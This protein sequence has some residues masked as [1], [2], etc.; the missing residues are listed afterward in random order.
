MAYRIDPLALNEL[1]Q[2]LYKNSLEAQVYAEQ[3]ARR[4]QRE[5]ESKGVFKNILEGMGGS[6][7]GVGSG[8]ARFVGADETANW[9]DTKGAELAP[10]KEFKD[11][12]S[13]EYF[14]DPRGALRDVS[15]QLGSMVA[16]APAAVVAGAA[17]PASVPVGVASVLGGS[18][19]RV[20][21]SKIAQNLAGKLGTEVGK[22]AIVNTGRTIAGGLGSGF[23]ESISEGGSA[24]SSA[25]MAGKSADDSR[26]IGNEVAVNNMPMLMAS[27][28][29]EY[30][31]LGGKL[32]NI[33]A[34]T[35][36]GAAARFLKS[37]FR[38]APQVVINALQNSG[39]ELIQQTISDKALGK[40]VGDLWN[41]S[42]WT[43]GQKEAFSKSLISSG[44][45][46][47]MAGL[48]HNNK[49]FKGT[50]ML[51]GIDTS[52]GVLENLSPEQY[53]AMQRQLADM[54]NEESIP[55]DD[56]GI[57]GMEETQ[58]IENPDLS[59]NPLGKA[60]A[61][62]YNNIMDE[63][64]S[65]YNKELR[66]IS[67]YGDDF[68]E[69]TLAKAER[70]AQDGTVRSVFK[71]AI[72][73]DV[74]A[75]KAIERQPLAVK[76]AL[77]GTMESLWKNTIEG[78]NNTEDTTERFDNIPLPTED[79]TNGWFTNE[80]NQL[81]HPS[82]NVKV[83]L[84][85]NQERIIG[86]IFSHPTTDNNNL[87]GKED[88]RRIILERALQGDVEAQKAFSRQ[89][90]AIKRA[91][92]D[93]HQKL[94]SGQDKLD[95]EVRNRWHLGEQL[96]VNAIPQEQLTEDKQSR[97]NSAMQSQSV[98][99]ALQAAFNGDRYAQRTIS[100]YPSYIKR[101][102]FNRD[103]EE[104]ANKETQQIQ[105]MDIVEQQEFR[106]QE[107][108]SIT[109]F[110]ENTTAINESAV[111][112]AMQANTLANEQ[113]VSSEKEV[114]VPKPVRNKW[115]TK[116]LAKVEDKINTPLTTAQTNEAAFALNDKSLASLFKRAMRGDWKS[117]KE[118]SEKSQIVRAALFKREEEVTARNLEKKKKALLA[119]LVKNE[120][121]AQTQ[122]TRN[123]L[124][125][126]GKSIA[127]TK[128][129]SKNIAVG[130]VERKQGEKAQTVNDK[131]VAT[132]QRV[133]GK[134]AEVR[135]DDN[136]NFNVRYR[137]AEADDLI[138]SHLAKNSDD[139]AINPNYPQEWQ[140][141]SRDRRAMRLQI[142]TMVN[143]LNPADLAESRNINNGSPLVNKE[144]IVENGN[145]RTIAITM[146]HK[147]NAPSRA[148]YIQYLKDNA[149][150]FGF[151]KND[152]EALSNPILVRERIDEDIEI[153]KIINSVDGGARLGASEQALADSKKITETTLTFYDKNSKGDL[154]S[155]GNRV[156]VGKLLSGISSA[157]DLNAL[158]TSDGSINQAGILRVRNA[159]F[160]L[161][162]G[163][164]D[165][166]GKM[167]ESTDNN[168]RAITNAMLGAAPT[169]AT[170][171]LKIDNGNLV[172]YNYWKPLIEACEKTMHL[173]E[174]GKGIES[175]LRERVLF[176]E[177]ETNEITRSLLAFLDENK[178]KSNNILQMLEGVAQGITNV[179]HPEQMK[180]FDSANPTMLDIYKN[181]I[182]DVA[183]LET[184]LFLIQPETRSDNKEQQE[185]ENEENKRDVEQS[186]QT[187]G[188]QNQDTK[189]KQNAQTDS[190]PTE[191]KGL[192]D[193][194]TSSQEKKETED[195]VDTQ[196]KEDTP[197][198]QKARTKREMFIAQ[199]SDGID[200][201]KAVRTTLDKPITVEK[202][203]ANNQIPEEHKIHNGTSMALAIEKAADIKEY[204]VSTSTTVTGK[205]QNKLLY[206]DIDTGITLNNTQ[207]EYFQTLT[208]GKE[209]IYTNVGTKKEQEVKNETTSKKLVYGNAEEFI[210]EE[211]LKEHSRTS[212]RKSLAK[213]ERDLLQD[214]GGKP[215]YRRLVQLL[216][217]GG[218]PFKTD[219]ERSGE[220]LCKVYLGKAKDGRVETSLFGL[221]ATR[222]ID[223]VQEE[224]RKDIPTAEERIALKGKLGDPEHRLE[225]IH[226]AIERYSHAKDL[227]ALRE[228]IRSDGRIKKLLLNSNRTELESIELVSKLGGLLSEHDILVAF[229]DMPISKNGERIIAL[230][231]DN[232]TS[233]NVPTTNTKP[234]IEERLKNKKQT[235]SSIADFAR[236]EKLIK[237]RIPHSKLVKAKDGFIVQL[238][239]G[240]MLGI[241]VNADATK[242]GMNTIT[243]GLEHYGVNSNQYTMKE[244]TDGIKGW[245]QAI[246][247]TA[248]LIA[249]TKRATAETLDHEL[250]HQVMRTV[251]KDNEVKAIYK[252]LIPK[253]K[254]FESLT[255]AE[256]TQLEEKIANEYAAWTNGNRS[257]TMF[258]KLWKQIKDFARSLVSLFK[259]IDK[260]DVFR[261][262]ESGEVYNR[263]YNNEQTKADTRLLFA[264][265]NAETA[266][267]TQLLHAKTS[268]AMSRP[269]SK[270]FTDTGWFR[271]MDGEWRFEIADNEAKFSKEFMTQEVLPRGKEYLLSEVLQHDKL[272]AAY[273]EELKDVKVKI[274]SEKAGYA[275]YNDNDKTIR[276]A[277]NMP[278]EDRSLS[279]LHEV[280]HA[281]QDIEG[282]TRGSSPNTK[283]ITNIKQHL[284][285]RTLVMKDLLQKNKNE[286]R[287]LS[288]KVKN[289]TKLLPL[290]KM[291]K[292]TIELNAIASKLKP[293]H[294]LNT[295]DINKAG[296]MLEKVLSDIANET[297]AFTPQ[298]SRA[299][300]NAIIRALK[301]HS[302]IARTLLNN[303][304]SVA[305]SEL[306]NKI[307]GNIQALDKNS[308]ETILKDINEVNRLK[309]TIKQLNT[310]LQN[311]NNLV[312]KVGKETRHGV[313]RRVAGEVEAYN[314]EERYK[315]WEDYKDKHPF[316]TQDVHPSESV[317]DTVTG[318]AGSKVL[319]TNPN[320]DD[321][322]FSLADKV[323]GMFAKDTDS[324]ENIKAQEN[325]RTSVAR[326]VPVR[327]GK[328]FLPTPYE[329]KK[330]LLKWNLHGDFYNVAHAVGYFID[331]TFPNLRYYQEE[332]VDRMRSLPEYDGHLVT[333]EE[334]RREGLA[335]FIADYLQDEDFAQ[336]TYPKLY[337]EFL[338][339]LEHNA[340][341]ATDLQNLQ[342]AISE[343][344][345]LTPESRVGSSLSM[346][347]ER[348]FTGKVKEQWH[349]FYRNWIDK[350][351]ALKK[352][353]ERI[354][355][356]TGV[357]DIDYAYDVYK[358]ARMASSLSS[359]RA[360]MVLA[361]ADTE[362]D[363]DKLREIYPNIKHNVS[364][365][366]VLEKIKIKDMDKAY[367]TY[368]QENN[369][370]T[371]EHA[372]AAYLSSNALL[373]RNDYNDKYTAS[374]NRE[375]AISVVN[376]A[377]QEIVEAAELA[378]KLNEN[379][380]GIAL[381]GGLVSQGV[382]DHLTQK[383]KAYAP[384]FRDFA[385]NEDGLASFESF[386]NSGG[387]GIGD[388]ATTIHNLT[389]TGST[390]KVINPLE[391]M[392]KNVYATIDRAERNKVAQTFIELSE[393]D[394]VDQFVEEL[395]VEY[396]DKVLTDKDGNSIK[397]IYGNAKKIRVPKDVQSDA[398]K[399]IFT[400]MV[401]GEKRAFRTTAEFYPAI[402]GY[403]EQSA[404]FGASL[405][406][407]AAKILRT[408]AT[409]TPEFMLRNWFRDNIFAGVT[410]ETGFRPFIDSIKA[411]KK[412]KNDAEF[413]AEINAA[414]IAMSSMSG[415]DRATARK[416]LSDMHNIVDGVKKT[417]AS[418]A[419]HLIEKLMSYSELV[420][421]STRAAEYMR[422]KEMG[423]SLEE[424]GYLAKEVTLD[425]SRSG[426]YGQRVNMAV[427]FFNACIQG[428][429]KLVRLL[430]NKP[431]R[432]MQ[433]ITTHII[434]P[435]LLLWFMN[436][437]E[438]WYKELPEDV[439]NRNWLFKVGD[440]IMK[441]PKPQEAGY[442]FGSGVERALSE[443]FGGA[444][445]HAMREWTST[446]MDA[447][448]PSFLPTLFLPLVE[449]QTNYSFFMKKNVVGKR[450]QALPDVEQYNAYTSEFAKG[451]GKVAGL[452]PMKIDNTVRGYTGSMGVFATQALDSALKENTPTKLWS[453]VAG[454]RN[455]THTENK[456]SQSVADWYELFDDI[457]KE[458]TAY[459]VQGKPVAYVTAANKL[460]K[461]IGAIQQ[462]IRT[463]TT[464]K[465]I[466]P[467]KKREMID[468]ANKKIVQLAK[469]GLEKFGKYA[470]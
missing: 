337:Q 261:K 20:G 14:T 95:F 209:E 138:S 299:F 67:D 275:S 142:S 417:P 402:V 135:T 438:E 59:D 268:R 273:P 306:L 55:N 171:K 290:F 363:M 205:T 316:V 467:D 3:E 118:V 279:I 235:Q 68:D 131:D 92:I 52:K 109:P 431:T 374:F 214:V 63:S 371:W 182:D 172:E 351:I 369:L 74:L 449:W 40:Q 88:N 336:K 217:L 370:K 136:T 257:A 42:T 376:N 89:D 240:K 156:F 116:E 152:V 293:T 28:A 76:K 416:S 264:G 132:R 9:L 80:I 367:P 159:L 263:K 98:R 7:A 364:L 148:K 323:Q 25:L 380:L 145:G 350:Q 238:H 137:L 30:L 412:L 221:S 388:V 204:R 310:E 408:G 161:A 4:K 445:K 111:Q 334:I 128:D 460:N 185:D 176:S 397:D 197:K 399:S 163:E 29:A 347:D 335:R 224:F 373:E 38:A 360:E 319:D 213:M 256:L 343:W 215:L 245:Y 398:R 414:G 241:E 162:Y 352:L 165:L 230:D 396:K 451:V 26:S 85:K 140:P 317:I 65:W 44:V 284:N 442:V 297:N 450:E 199:H 285:G 272:F 283:T 78:A 126:T 70:M 253:G 106:T 308:I 464:A 34:K 243:K 179:G 50:D 175:F 340:E 58:P 87:G 180:V 2:E 154:Q 296:Y 300:R 304:V 94:W 267:K 379:V 121:Q 12:F 100:G 11:P 307:P 355:E 196:T 362:T 457:Q 174:I 274:T 219:K 160:A 151:T 302:I 426:V 206:A 10:T 27:N 385:E 119:T 244:I 134:I 122:N 407:A 61:K 354:S 394:G 341:V 102:L 124:K 433:M 470:K 291:A 184:D 228:A 454:V 294:L 232:S 60:M 422:A 189:P 167:A 390:L 158:T 345:N 405:L 97:L 372:L 358:Q 90:P 36:E 113:N 461:D 181:A 203:K 48:Y 251:L 226:N 96:K 254:S 192:Q 143:N 419:K 82:N 384:M 452:S 389:E 84:S 133:Y 103:V 428:G 225:A 191:S 282:L 262:I 207:T 271:G 258:G 458:H 327:N 339:E 101:A 39:E 305:N 427:P 62:D 298:Q 169:L 314:V 239:N 8:V 141:R 444:S 193:E 437:D 393:L 344:Q 71:K 22:Q 424:A 329:N 346:A 287:K 155:A 413:R 13:A 330:N 386:L 459:G 441:L 149:D 37:P 69:A 331:K 278:I 210:F 453:E 269:I 406:R 229:I 249:L 146:M 404:V 178:F 250:L 188:H 231:Y 212:S 301:S 91:V 130:G 255:K 120:N 104:R 325:I 35:G 436:H 328:I 201:G 23:A 15:G 237:E 313:Y 353:M 5:E 410:S 123:E 270:I 79:T 32:G 223:F 392:I 144:G 440:T 200:K 194:I 403:S 338:V 311:H 186:G 421:T 361:S 139:F 432:T 342:G 318:Y 418:F 265:K 202:T 66:Q 125:G 105:P 173:R 234:T 260:E 110:E 425:F 469:I 16:L 377:P 150:R 242:L 51:K 349:G 420:E 465:N 190:K 220:R 359:K 448:L 252:H 276:I 266:N 277:E 47:G 280:Q 107:T 208:Q 295:E 365:K 456:R 281:I 112:G 57:Q 31:L 117:Q 246:D 56:F 259:P 462:D 292:A 41:P 195:T 218:I 333:A 43:D 46:G 77:F 18:L 439:K 187:K 127:N 324:N 383:Y 288:S 387:N 348:T 227:S 86:K 357:Q 33:G 320:V 382:Y 315:N 468:K 157:N 443:A 411:I 286:L 430:K 164:S 463:I 429:D 366:K 45:I 1:A 183:P 54:Q 83:P 198:A 21:A 434:L 378:Y 303:V 170:V 75:R 236:V 49:A 19:A 247:G 309:D 129:N 53:R 168:V 381:D 356:V 447:F 248:G 391:S 177:S 455:F 401:N 222:F 446:V 17:L 326:F 415:Y 115:Y 114:Q 322:R 216:Q 466:S 211:F 81:N 409:V 321:I 93:A 6:I 312:N 368:L 108:S 72:A 166:L 73:G 375:D 400:V 147:G 423:L 99:N 153:G 233:D 289:T 435:S 24:I 395:P 332:Y 64:E